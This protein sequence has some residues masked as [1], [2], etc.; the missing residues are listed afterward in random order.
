MTDSS[1]RGAAQVDNGMSGKMRVWDPLVYVFHWGLVVA[2]AVAWLTAEE[3][4]TV[5]EIEAT[6][7]RAWSRSA[8][9][10]AWSA[11]A[12]RASSSS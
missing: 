7:S 6:R 5:H 10:G 2:F 11:A 8:S 9:S 12:T 3:L 4:F 1:A